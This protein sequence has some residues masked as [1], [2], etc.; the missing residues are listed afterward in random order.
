MKRINYLLFFLLTLCNN[1]NLTA[2]SKH[3]IM[4]FIR[5]INTKQVVYD[6]PIQATY[7]GNFVSSNHNGQIILPRKTQASEFTIVITPQIIPVF[8]ILNNISHLQIPPLQAASMYHVKLEVNSAN[9]LPEWQVKQT[10]IPANRTIPLHS[11][12]ILGHPA[13]FTMQTGASAVLLSNQLILPSIYLHKPLLNTELT[14][15]LPNSRPFLSK[16]ETAYTLTPY[17]YATIQTK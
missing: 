15:T 6:S 3:A 8:S 11:I 13:N 12:V 14:I 16:I 10:T 2:M 1:Y 5:D 7:G 4:L 9:N 17:G